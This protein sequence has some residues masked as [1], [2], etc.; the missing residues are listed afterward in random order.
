MHP[1]EWHKRFIEGRGEVEDDERPERP[2]VSKT[3]E[4]IVKISEIVDLRVKRL[5]KSATWRA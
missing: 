5:I 1:S 4:N 2:S 3:K